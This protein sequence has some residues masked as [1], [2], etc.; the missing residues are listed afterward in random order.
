[1]CTCEGWKNDAVESVNG[2]G[3][4]KI[5][6]YKEKKRTKYLCS[7]CKHPLTEHGDLLNIDQKELER[8]VV[9]AS[10]INRLYAASRP[11]A[12]YFEDTLTRLKE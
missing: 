2:K 12:E 1:M 9:V 6:I 3:K 10:E 11:D 5:R 7:D 8:R 4:I